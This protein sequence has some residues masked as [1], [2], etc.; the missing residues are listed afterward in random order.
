MIIF[1]YKANIQVRNNIVRVDREFLCGGFL[2]DR[3][4]V[5]TAAH[6]ITEEIEVNVGTQS[7][8][9]KVVPNN[10]FPT[11]GSMFK[12]FLGIHNNQGA[13]HGG[14]VSPGVRA[15]VSQ[16]IRHP[17]YDKETNLNDIAIL[18]LA[19][20]VKLDQN[21]QLA[22]LPNPAV[23]VYPTQSNIPTF[24]IGWGTLYSNGPTAS[25][26]QNVRLNVYD[27]KFCE[28][29]APFTTK[30]W[31]RQICAGNIIFI[32]SNSRNL[33]VFFKR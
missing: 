32:Y 29:V 25:T 19:N 8:T 21:V 30:D 1:Q 12:V 15:V 24:A 4:T 11:Q 3:T 16:V 7:Y 14:D 2:V 17:N 13:L 22:C 10:F 6:C 23:R 31:T 33:V 20:P 18:K 26:L 9:I 28:N 27:G 5:V